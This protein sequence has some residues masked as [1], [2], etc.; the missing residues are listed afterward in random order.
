MNNKSKR[1]KFVKE[2][3]AHLISLGATV[4]E[5]TKRAT[6][7]TLGTCTLTVRDESDH[8]QVF[9]IFSRFTKCNKLTGNMNS[10]HNYNGIDGECGLVG[11]KEYLNEIAEHEEKGC[12]VCGTHTENTVMVQDSIFT[13]DYEN[14]KMVKQ[15]ACG[16]CVK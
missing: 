14:F 5:E 7:Y 4:K 15:H 8:T 10:K 11:W 12:F 13:G 3:N 9:S 2:V 1:I 6:E 16:Q